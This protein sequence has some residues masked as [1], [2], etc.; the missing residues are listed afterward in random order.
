MTIQEIRACLEVLTNQKDFD[1]Q[2]QN[3]ITQ[4]YLIKNILNMRNEDSLT[5]FNNTQTQFNS[6]N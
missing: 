5:S 1:Q 3:Q 2:I 4:E 6:Q